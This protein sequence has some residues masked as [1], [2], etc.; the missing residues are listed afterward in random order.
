MADFFFLDACDF[1]WIFLPVIGVERYFVCSDYG[2]L[3]ING[4]K[5]MVL[6]PRHDT[7]VLYFSQVADWA[8]KKDH[9]GKL[10][11]DL[12]LVQFCRLCQASSHASRSQAHTSSSISAIDHSSR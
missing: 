12:G 6:S 2:F 9:S 4:K 1:I 5:Y 7:F 10:L 3:D 8:F 11:I